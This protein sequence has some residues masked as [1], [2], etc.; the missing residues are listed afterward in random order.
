VVAQVAVCGTL[1]LG[2]GALVLDIGSAYT[3][4]TELQVAADAAALA[5]AAQLAGSPDT[6]PLALALATANEYAQLN[7]P[8]G[9]EVAVYPQDVEFG[10]AVY[11]PL[12][13]KFRF[14][15]GGTNFD[16]LRVT[17]R[18]T[19]DEGLVV[20]PFLFA[21]I[22][23]QE[24]KQLEAQAAAVFIPRDISVVIDLSNSMCYDS[25]LRYWN[26]GDGGFSN[27]R[28]VWCALNGPE[29]Q[30]PYLPGSDVDETEYAGDTGPTFG[31][32]TNWGNQLFPTSY[33]P[34]T[35]P[36]LWYIRKGYATSVPA[37]TS[38]LTA[39]GYKSAERSALLSGSSDSNSAHWRNRC[40][41]LLGLTQWRSGKAGAAFPGGGDGDNLVEDPEVTW[42][43]V[44]S[45]SVSWH[46]R[47][48]VDWVQSHY[49]SQFK[50]R[51]GLKTFTDFLM[52]DRPQYNQTN[53]LWATPEQPLRAIKDAVQ[54]MTDVIEALESL[55]HMS[56]EIFAQTSRHEVDLT[57]NLAL[58]PG[59]LYGRQSGHYDR[60]TN[61]GGGLS[62]AY[63]ELTSERA[64]QSAAKVIVLMS[65][66][67]PN[68]DEYGNG[69]GDG[70][71]AAVNWALK[72]ARQAADA[73]MRIY[74]VSVGYNVDRSLMQQIAVIGRGQEFYAA[75]NPEEY[76]EELEMIFRTLGGKR[77]V[78]LIE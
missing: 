20:V 61:M 10:R 68:V 35:D 44:P 25:E 59:T 49:L 29:P 52:E 24:S 73:N 18:H 21:P 30:R 71:P 17:L 63:S 77:P 28:D 40:G 67:V 76:T 58:I 9:F 48:Y 13:E 32:L 41:V 1:M 12:T 23:G 16:A 50:Y 6:D 33:N 31:Y 62:R 42:I 8:N 66:G 65:D 78:A 22:F 74:T 15:P 55:D 3:T 69:V 34:S 51:Y 57:D 53:N 43:P 2:M 36:G 14:Q 70:A 19:A 72:M 46:W 64:R 45:F 56:L 60:S 39:T 5:A 54:S 37:I 75:G 4:Q 38:L 47:N 27:L 11:D 26:R 7:T